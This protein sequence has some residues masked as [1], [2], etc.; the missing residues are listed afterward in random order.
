MCKR[1]GYGYY[2][3]EL[4][5]VKSKSRYSCASAIYFNLGTEIINENCEFDFYFNKTNIKPSVLDGGHKLF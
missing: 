1:I 2:C 5:V 3:K 4:F